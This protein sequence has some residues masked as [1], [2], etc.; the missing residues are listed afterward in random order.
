MATDFASL[1]VNA[2]QDLGQPP[3]AADGWVGDPGDVPV[4]LAD[5]Y[6][7]AGLHPLNRSHHRVLL[8]DELRRERDTRVVFAV[9]NQEAVVWAYDIADPSDDPEVW[10]G[11]PSSTGN[12]IDAWYSEDMTLSS[13][14]I[15]MWRWLAAADEAH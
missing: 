2:L 1:Y 9:E 11:H 5:L 15:S 3:S 12:A 6:R 8:P 4:A 7:V 13:F 14:I 10:Q